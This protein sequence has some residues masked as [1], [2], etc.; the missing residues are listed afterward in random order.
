MK[1][2]FVLLLIL[3]SL[4][5]NAQKN[6]IKFGLVTM[7]ELTMKVYEKD[8]SASAV[9]L[10]DYGEF[11]K[12]EYT[13][14]TKIKIFNS[15][16]YGWGDILT[17]IYH[18]GNPGTRL[19][20]IEAMTYNLEEGKIVQTKPDKQ[21]TFK[22]KFNDNIDLLRFAMPKIKEGSVIEYRYRINSSGIPD[23]QFQ[24]FIPTIYSEFKFYQIDFLS[25]QKFVQGY[26]PLADFEDNGAYWKWVM[27]DVP[28]FQSEPF[29]GSSNNYLA[30][31]KIDIAAAS[32]MPRMNYGWTL[33]YTDL[34]LLSDWDDL[35]KNYEGVFLFKG[36]LTEI[37]FLKKAVDELN[38]ENLST[39]QK[40][41]R[42][43]S[44]VVKNMKWGG[45]NTTARSTSIK[46]AFEKKQGTSGDINYI[47][48]G[49]LNH[50]GVPVIP[51]L[52]STADNGL[53]RQ[54]VPNQRQFNRLIL[55]VYYK[56]ESVFLDATN[57][58]LGISY[59]P[60]EAVSGLAYVMDNPKFSWFDLRDKYKAKNIVTSK[61][62][63]NNHGDLEGEVVVTKTGYFASKD[64]E[65]LDKG[66]EKKY[67]ERFSV[68]QN[69]EVL[70]AEFENIENVNAPLLEKYQI[71]KAGYAQ[72]D[73]ATLIFNPLLFPGLTS[74]PFVS[75]TRVYPID[76]GFAN[77]VSYTATILLPVGYQ[78]DELPA[79]KMILLP[80]KAGK[81]TFNAVHQNG[82][83][84]IVYQVVFNKSF[85][86][87]E[88]YGII[89]EFYN[90]LVAKHLEPVVLKRK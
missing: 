41:E 90:I 37:G 67:I 31:V 56:G 53:I 78:I 30:K 36:S 42:I 65:R 18:F 80:E 1:N 60:E 66:E 25:F 35:K 16:G 48:W 62:E 87:P 54:E 20:F 46:T 72:K 15:A 12:G 17:P 26:H 47:L 33:N 73:E 22:E 9:V 57:K 29:S 44:Y 8:S 83:L 3:V 52:I 58:Y 63:I 43:Y 81:F 71:K 4:F 85:F 38:L 82:E 76:F 32:Q 6:P 19:E 11:N 55:K 27:K 49:M 88:E 14:H 13:H 51:S 39:D 79:P 77:E 24:R 34:R 61:L 7:E 74:N 28:A 10:Y 21:F 84:R 86:S 23:W 45:L 59:L 89:R 64:R 50:A 40:I 5:G 69:V 2:G 70:K 75:K 68:N